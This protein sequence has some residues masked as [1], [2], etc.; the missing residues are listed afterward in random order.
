MLA[1]SIPDEETAL[2]T[3]G[4]AWPGQRQLPPNVTNQIQ[5]LGDGQQ[6]VI[7]FLILS[8]SSIK[9]FFEV[10]QC[11]LYRLK[12]FKAFTEFMWKLLSVSGI[13]NLTVLMLNRKESD[14]KL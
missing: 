13:P 14:L 12:V 3:G 1:D 2:K 9:F 8:Q 4:P 6:M 5:D 7:S 11:S 10:P